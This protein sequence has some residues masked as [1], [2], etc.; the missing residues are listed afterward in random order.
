MFSP[1]KYFDRIGFAGKAAPDLQTLRA[2]H[3]LHPA[4]IPFENIDVLMNRGIDLNVQAVMEKLVVSGRGGY[5]FEHNGLLMA[6][7]RSIGYRVEPLLARVQWRRPADAPPAPRTH[8]VLRVFMDDAPWLV[9]VGFGGLVLTAPLQFKADIQQETQHESFRLME[10]E[11]GFRLDAL[12]DDQW[13]PVYTLG[14]QAVPEI[15][16]EVANWYT[17]RHPQSHFQHN[18]MVARTTEDTRYTLLNYRLTVR[19]RGADPVKQV[20]DTAGLMEVL[21]T[22]FLLPVEPLWEQRLALLPRD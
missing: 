16:F 2:L 5:C 8:M 20:L 11:G 1:D 9:D 12:L 14:R 17:A 22:V 4:A 18:L 13:H 19:A 10:I 15:D 21:S 3:Q 6:V 7:L